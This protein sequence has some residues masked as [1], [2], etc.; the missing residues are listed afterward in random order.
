MSLNNKEEYY[1]EWEAAESIAKDQ[2]G[3]KVGL[4]NGEWHPITSQAKNDAG[5]SVVIR[6]ASKSLDNNNFE[7]KFDAAQ[8]ATSNQQQNVEDNPIS[9]NYEGTVLHS[10]ARTPAKIA[11]GVNQFG[12]NLLP[13]HMQKEADKFYNTNIADNFDSVDRLAEGGLNEDVRQTEAKFQKQRAAQGREGFDAGAFAGDLLFTAPALMAKPFQIAKGAKEI[14]NAT[15]MAKAAG[16]GAVIEGVQPVTKEGNYWDNKISD[17]ASVAGASAL[18]GPLSAGLARILSPKL[19]TAGN[20]SPVNRLMKQNINPS[21]GQ[22]LG[23]QS[24]RFEDAA[25]YFPG[26]GNLINSAERKAQKDLNRAVYDLALKGTGKTAKDMPVGAEGF[27]K[28]GKI[29]EQQ[30]KDALEGTS[31]KVDDN[32]ISKLSS[33]SPKVNKLRK[34][35]QDDFNGVLDDVIDLIG[36]KSKTD[37]SKLD[38]LLKSGKSLKTNDPEIRALIQAEMRGANKSSKNTSISIEDKLAKLEIG[39]NLSGREF[40]DIQSYLS[41]ELRGFGG[42]EDRFAQREADVIRSLKKTLEDHFEHLNPTK[43]PKL[44]QVNKN[45]RREE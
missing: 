30:Y 4:I 17:T 14:W 22:I 26:I 15:N 10:F 35:H 45:W 16:Q 28:L 44:K 8:A 3:N 11:R 12:Y 40:K 31:F 39:N 2:N 13:E 37:K 36:N 21:L 29:F 25:S 33:L 9:N 19:S 23:G 6:S 34:D 42:N 38:E 41:K 32:L 7:N 43:A 1:M 27:T 5:N 18:G 20:N 24:K